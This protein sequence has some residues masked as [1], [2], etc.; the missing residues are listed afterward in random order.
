MPALQHAHCPASPMFGHLH[1]GN[2]TFVIGVSN[3]RSS[4]LCFLKEQL[5]KALFSMASSP[6]ESKFN[7]ISFAGKVKLM[8]L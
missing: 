2:I 6:A 3:T 4:K 5:I 7:I 1:D 8:Q